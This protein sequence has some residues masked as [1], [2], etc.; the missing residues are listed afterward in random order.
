MAGLERGNESCIPVYCSL[1]E[2]VI[3]LWIRDSRRWK[4]LARNGPGLHI[5]YVV[6]VISPDKCR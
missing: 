4:M 2:S 5:Q 3:F 6:E 1:L